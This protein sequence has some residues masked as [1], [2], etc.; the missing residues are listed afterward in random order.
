MGNQMRGNVTR[1]LIASAMLMVVAAPVANADSGS[2]NPDPG[3]ADLELVF[4][5]ADDAIVFL[6]AKFLDGSGDTVCVEAHYDVVNN[7]HGPDP[8]SLVYEY[9]DCPTQGCVSGE[10]PD[11][12][13]PGIHLAVS[14]TNDGVP[15]TSN[16]VCAFIY[17]SGGVPHAAACL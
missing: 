16:G 1:A 5:S 13:H 14:D 8:W 11:D 17:D 2:A 10:D 9:Y 12:I 6:A 7:L 15:A 4:C 3:Y